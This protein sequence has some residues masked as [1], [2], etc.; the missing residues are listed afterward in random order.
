MDVFECVAER[1]RRLML[2]LLSRR[3]RSA[4]E[5]GAAMGSLTQP[6]VSSHLRALR[7]AGLVDVRVDAQRRIY[8]L[9]KDGLAK[10]E[11]WLEKLKGRRL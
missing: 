4:G 5:L 2:S 1:H 6:A 3:E 10:F 9:R 11:A 7:Q 8:S